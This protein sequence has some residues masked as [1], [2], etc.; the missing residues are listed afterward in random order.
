MNQI[1]FPPKTTGFYN[2]DEQPPVL[3]SLEGFMKACEQMASIKGFELLTLFDYTD[4]PSKSY[5]LQLMKDQDGQGFFIFVNKYSPLIAFSKI[6][7]I[8]WEGWNGEGEMPQNHYVD[9]IELTSYF[10]GMDVIPVEVLLMPIDADEAESAVVVQ[11]LQDAEFA[12]FSFFAPQ[13]LGNLVFNNWPK[14]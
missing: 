6:D 3:Q 12:E 13:N 11:Q 9:M 7:A 10:H 1:I 14:R 4:I 5:H 2:P 8:N